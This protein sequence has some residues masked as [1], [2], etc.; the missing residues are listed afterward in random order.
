MRLF[1]LLCAGGF[2]L[3]V[4]AGMG[5]CVVW[6][7]KDGIEASNTNL[8]RIQTQLETIDRDIA[9]V[10]QNLDQLETRLDPMGATLASMD[11]QLKDLQTR[12]DATNGHLESL[13]KTI[14]NIDSTIPFL[15]FSGDDEAEQEALEEGESKK[16]EEED[17][18]DTP[19]TGSGDE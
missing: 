13:R 8:E 15:N 1:R 3:L 6:D 4:S 12:L 14:N 2:L 10:N 7:I 19:T 9:R 16:I 11:T 18:S 17:G 5:G